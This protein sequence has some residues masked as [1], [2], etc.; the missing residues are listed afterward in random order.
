MVV[1]AQSIIKNM[2]FFIC[3]PPLI[4]FYPRLFASYCRRLA[5]IAQRRTDTENMMKAVT[6]KGVGVTISGTAATPSVI[7]IPGN[8]RGGMGDGVWANT[9]YQAKNTLP[10]ER[11]ALTINTRTKG[12]K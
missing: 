12:P 8:S 11:R 10:A 3:S 9:K 6:A 1:N 2:F 5:N 7:K 4:Y